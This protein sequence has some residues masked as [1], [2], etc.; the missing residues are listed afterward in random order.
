MSTY[1]FEW[2]IIQVYFI[3]IAVI[4]CRN[5]SYKFSLDEKREQLSQYFL[6]TF[7]EFWT[8]WVILLMHLWW[9]QKPN[10]ARGA[11]LFLQLIN[12]MHDRHQYLHTDTSVWKV[13]PS[14]VL[15]PSQCHTVQPKSV[16]CL[17]PMIMLSALGSLALRRHVP[18]PQPHHLT[19]DAYLQYRHH[20][21]VMSHRQPRIDG[22]S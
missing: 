4:S 19:P 20:V 8:N 5:D 2:I 13:R 14:L 12:M 6:I 9:G 3:T 11:W 15:L 21:V 10:N 17:S 22:T 7:P 1:L 18:W 16:M